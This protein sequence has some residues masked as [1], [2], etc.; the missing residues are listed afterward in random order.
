MTYRSELNNIQEDLHG[1][2]KWAVNN[3]SI[4]DCLFSQAISHD[5]IQRSLGTILLK[6]I[7]EEKL[8]DHVKQ[9]SVII[10][11]NG[12]ARTILI[13]KIQSGHPLL[14]RKIKLQNIPLCN[15]LDNLAYPLI[16][17]YV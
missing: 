12:I 1:H 11:V 7:L 14:A 4:S 3:Y 2:F 5:D 10:H 6:P 8:R 15:I 16:C 13:S 17:I 9:V